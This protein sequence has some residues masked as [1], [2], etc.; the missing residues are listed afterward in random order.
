MDP[1]IKGRFI[2]GYISNIRYTRI[3]TNIYSNTP[4][5]RDIINLIYPGYLFK[6]RDNLLYYIYP[7]SIQHLYMPHNM[8]RDVITATY[9]EKHYFSHTRVL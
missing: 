3:I 4:S 5:N 1:K 7:D 6:L 2:E 8:V 9:N